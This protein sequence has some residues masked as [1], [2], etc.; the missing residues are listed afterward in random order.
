MLHA[1]RSRRCSKLVDVRNV[2]A[3]SSGSLRVAARYSRSF[4]LEF[5]LELLSERSDHAEG[6]VEREGM[7]R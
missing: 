3:V 7:L 1:A 5:K 6:L 4:Q 2:K